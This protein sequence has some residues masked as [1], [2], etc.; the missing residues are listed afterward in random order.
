MSFQTRII[1]WRVSTERKQRMLF[2]VSCVTR[3]RCFTLWFEWKQLMHVAQLTQ[4]SIRSR[5]FVKLQLNPWCHV[6][7][8]TDLLATFLDVDRGNYIAV[9]GRVRELSECIKN[10]LIC[11]LKTN[12]AFMGLERHAGKWVITKF[13]FSVN[14]H[15]FVAGILTHCLWLGQF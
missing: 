5:T 12:K 13:S 11:V 4:N 9:Y 3:I 1:F 7:Y 10:I 14:R 15:I 8:F 2:C 6:D